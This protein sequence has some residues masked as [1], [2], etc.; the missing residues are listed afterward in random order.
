MA[1]DTAQPRGHRALRELLDTVLPRSSTDV[2]D[3][4]AALHGSLVGLTLRPA[5]HGGHAKRIEQYI[6]EV[7]ELAALDGSLGWLAA[8]FNAAAAEL[9]GHPDH[10]DS[11]VWGSD[12]DALVAAAFSGDGTLDSDRRLTGHWEA[13]VGAAYADWFL[14]PADDAGRCWALVPRAAVR[15]D[16]DSHHTALVPAGI[17]DLSVSGVAVPHRHI[18]KGKLAVAIAGPGAAAAVVGSADGVWR[19]HV[20]RVRAR[21]ATSYG[22]DEVTDEAAAQVAWAA[23]DIDAARLHIAS[24]AKSQQT[25]RN[26]AC[27]QAVARAASAADRLL[28]SSRHALDA[29][30]PVTLQWRDVQAGHR[31]AVGVLGAESR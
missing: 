20:E 9:A 24:S 7:H 22:G 18:C 31:L 11:D 6:S 13:V 21:L 2:V 26:L 5:S 14:L 3:S 30:D 15:I 12:V 29:A 16:T 19:S 28:G 4:F 23:S 8:M 1:V 17:G 25:S 10:A 27:R